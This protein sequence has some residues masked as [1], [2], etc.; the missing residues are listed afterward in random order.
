MALMGR[1]C[2]DVYI[3]DFIISAIA[4]TEVITLRATPKDK[5]IT[6]PNWPENYPE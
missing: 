1:H 4:A 5:Y 6:S 2:N 3:S